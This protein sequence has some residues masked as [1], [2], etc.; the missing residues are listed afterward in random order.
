MPVCCC[1]QQ[2]LSCAIVTM[3]SSSQHASY[4]TM[5][6]CKTLGL[7]SFGKHCLNLN[8]FGSRKIA[9]QY[10]GAVSLDLE[11]CSGELVITSGIHI[12]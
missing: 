3:G 1:K 10:Y 5:A 12:R 2:R 8:T 4:R 6:G 7:K 9:R 11:T